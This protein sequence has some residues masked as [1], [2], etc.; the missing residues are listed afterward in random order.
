MVTRSK[1]KWLIAILIA[2]MIVL[3]LVFL[4]WGF[5]VAQRIPVKEILMQ[6]FFNV[7]I[8]IWLSIFLDLKKLF[9]KCLRNKILTMVA[10]CKCFLVCPHKNVVN[11]RAWCTVILTAFDWILCPCMSLCFV[12]DFFDVFCLNM[13]FVIVTSSHN[14]SFNRHVW[15]LDSWFFFFELQLVLL[16]FSFRSRS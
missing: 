7:S 1:Q 12:I 5:S 16:S 15:G 2:N 10:F 4:C 8:T 13:F 11:M 6:E 14:R 3:F 9:C